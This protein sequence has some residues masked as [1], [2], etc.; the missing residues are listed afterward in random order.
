MEVFNKNNYKTIGLASV[1]AKVF[2]LNLQRFY[3]HPIIS[4]VLKLTIMYYILE[5]LIDLQTWTYVKGVF[6]WCVKSIRR[7]ESLNAFKKAIFMVSGS[8]NVIVT[9]SNWFIL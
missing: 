8:D 3:V 2:A 7:S 4:F 5:E 6:Y 9:H 1:V